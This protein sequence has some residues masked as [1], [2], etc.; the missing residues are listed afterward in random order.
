MA[1][2][3]ADFLFCDQPREVRPRRVDAQA[4]GRDGAVSRLGVARGVRSR[5]DRRCSWPDGSGRSLQPEDAPAGRAGCGHKS[6]PSKTR[7]EKTCRRLRPPRSLSRPLPAFRLRRRRSG[8]L[9]LD[10]EA[11]LREHWVD[12]PNSGL[13]EARRFQ[14]G[15]PFCGVSG[16]QT[17]VPETI[18]SSTSRA[19]ATPTIST[20]SPA[21]GRGDFSNRAHRG[22]VFRHCVARLDDARQKFVERPACSRSRGPAYPARKCRW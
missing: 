10:G 20:R 19:H 13:P 7:A 6:M 12:R 16:R 2:S 21:R 9:A 3:I 1:C 22:E 17:V 18:M 4:G 11:R 8:K 5:N 15:A 14:A